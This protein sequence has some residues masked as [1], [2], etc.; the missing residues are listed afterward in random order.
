MLSLIFAAI[1]QNPVLHCNHLART[2]HVHDRM[3]KDLS[4]EHSRLY[5]PRDSCEKTRERRQPHFKDKEVITV[6]AVAFHALISQHFLTAEDKRPDTST[7]SIERHCI[8]MYTMQIF[9]TLMEPSH[10][11]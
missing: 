6:A 8:A 11:A 1:S 2:L 9:I 5:D 4:R 7:D 10:Q 3:L